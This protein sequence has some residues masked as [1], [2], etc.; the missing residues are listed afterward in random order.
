M[1]CLIFF[2]HF[3]RSSGL[4][5]L[6]EQQRGFPC[7]LASQARK[8]IKISLLSSNRHQRAESILGEAKIQTNKTVFN[9][10]RTSDT[11]AGEYGLGSF[12]ITFHRRSPT[13]SQQNDAAFLYL[14]PHSTESY[15]I[16]LSNM[17]NTHCSRGTRT[18]SFAITVK[19]R[20]PHRVWRFV[21]LKDHQ[22][23]D[24]LGSAVNGARKNHIAPPLWL[25]ITRIQSWTFFVVMPESNLENGNPLQP[26]RTQLGIA[27]GYDDEGDEY[28]VK[29]KEE[30]AGDWKA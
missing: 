28:D 8:L 11:K 17:K 9:R 25:S 4:D 24:W 20:R 10:L 15:S 6:A 12:G 5:D 16:W 30:L 7:T 3:I 23:A 26:V 1:S 29:A 18:L 13:L 27:Y 19:L 14:V 2:Q 22:Q 21:L